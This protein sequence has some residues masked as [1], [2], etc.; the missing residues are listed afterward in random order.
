MR[1]AGFEPAF[2]L[3]SEYGINTYDTVLF[4][5]ETMVNT[6]PEIVEKFLRALTSG[7]EDGVANPDKAIDFVLEY[8]P[9]LSRE[10]Q[11]SRLQVSLPLIKPAGSQTGNMRA[12]VWEATHN[13]LLAQGI[14]ATSIDIQTVYT[15]SFL[16]N[17]YGK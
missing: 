13:I 1:E 14:L 11:F 17:I 16:E 3:P 6:Q 8:N 10:E 15:L 7:L 2:I 9:D 4:T 5:T 12:Q